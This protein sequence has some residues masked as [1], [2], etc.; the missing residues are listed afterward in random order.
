MKTKREFE[1]TCRDYKHGDPVYPDY[2]FLST[3][4]QSDIRVSTIYRKYGT[5]E[6]ESW[7]YE[8]MIFRG[9]EIIGDATGVDHFKVCQWIINNGGWDSDKFAERD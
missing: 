7:G 3:T 9:D 6:G 8:T 4:I 5:M 2:R 1:H